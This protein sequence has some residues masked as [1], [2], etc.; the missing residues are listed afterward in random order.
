METEKQKSQIM[1]VRLISAQQQVQNKAGTRK[2]FLLND[3][4]LLRTITYTNH[5]EHYTSFNVNNPQATY[6]SRSSQAGSQHVDAKSN[7]KIRNCPPGAGL[8]FLTRAL[9]YW[10]KS[11]RKTFVRQAGCAMMLRTHI[12]DNACILYNW[13]VWSV[14]T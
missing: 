6:K 14:D 8:L 4:V 10:E 12:T 5:P 7:S 11:L 9:S 3:S 2:H 13:H 1:S